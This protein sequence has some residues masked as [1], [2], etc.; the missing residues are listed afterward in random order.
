MSSADTCWLLTTAVVPWED[1]I[2]GLLHGGL[3]PVI[4]RNALTG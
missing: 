2:D 3:K 1:A 4:V